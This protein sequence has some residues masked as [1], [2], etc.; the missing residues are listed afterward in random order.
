M[1]QRTVW[2][3]PL[4]RHRDAGTGP[5]SHFYPLPPVEKYILASQGFNFLPQKI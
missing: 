3:A 2:T 4:K 1:N 5:L